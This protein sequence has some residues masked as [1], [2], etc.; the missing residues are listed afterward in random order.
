MEWGIYM[1]LV[2]L[3]VIPTVTLL[4]LPPFRF[5]ASCRQGTELDWEEVQRT[6]P[7]QYLRSPTAIPG[8]AFS[9][10]DFLGEHAPRGPDKT[11][12]SPF[13]SSLSQIRN[14]QDCAR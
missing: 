3:F 1:R 4:P 9:S 2:F 7:H 5:S 10:N 14:S 8:T 11:F 12:L 13:H 6:E